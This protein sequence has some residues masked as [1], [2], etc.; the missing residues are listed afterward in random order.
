MYNLFFY[1]IGFKLSLCNYLSQDES[2]IEIATRQDSSAEARKLLGEAIK[3][4]KKLTVDE[5]KVKYVP[6]LLKDFQDE[7]DALTRR[8]RFAEKV[9]LQLVKDILEAP[10]P[11]PFLNQGMELGRQSGIYKDEV[12]RLKAELAE[13][14]A[15]AHGIGEDAKAELLRLQ[16]ENAALETELTKLSNQ[17]ITIRELETRIEEFEQT[18]ENQVT[19]RLLSR[20]SELRKI[21]DTELESVRE[22]ET[23]AEARVAALHSALLEAQQGRDEAQANLYN[24]RARFDDELATKQAETDNCIAETIRLRESL[25]TVTAALDDLRRQRDLL[26]TNGGNA[27]VDASSIG[28]T[29][30][31]PSDIYSSLRSQIEVQKSRAEAAEEEVSRLSTAINSTQEENRRWQ[32]VLESQRQVHE[33]TV[34]DMRNRLNL[35]DTDIF[36]LRKELQERPTVTEMNNLRHQLSVLQSMHFNTLDE[37]DNGDPEYSTLPSKSGDDLLSLSSNSNG[38]TNSSSGGTGEVMEVTTLMLKRI[39]QLETKLVRTENNYSETKEALTEMKQEYEKAQE[40]IEEQ[41]ETIAKLE[42]IIANHGGNPSR[43]P[44]SPTKEGSDN[45]TV[46][47]GTQNVL[48]AQS[49]LDAILSKSSVPFTNTYPSSSNDHPSS[50]L[51]ASSTFGSPRRDSIV[52]EMGTPQPSSSFLM[53]PSSVTENDTSIVTVLRT[54]RD[55]FR[56]RV[57]E[58]ESEVQARVHELAEAHNRITKLS[59][60]NVKMYEKIRFLQSFFI[61]EPSSASSSSSSINNNASTGNNTSITVNSG[62]MINRSEL[63]ARSVNA[64]YSITGE[65]D[66]EKDYRKAYQDSLDPF[67]AFNKAQ[68]AKTYNRLSS[69]D[70][71]TLRGGSLIAGN[72]IARNFFLIYALLLH[73]L[74]AITL[75]HFTQVSHKECIGGEDDHTPG[76][77]HLPPGLEIRK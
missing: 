72:K 60:D 51:S 29:F 16:R 70:K 8:S 69:A 48:T 34:N 31:Q 5:E 73:I 15:S 54:Q 65:D 37:D 56:I 59:G 55:R 50:A 77:N 75:W 6:T 63:R 62:V 39:R 41:R 30:S 76:A 19:E 46:G 14:K 49:Q 40:L 11:V 35:R 53:S 17:D 22:A 13:T 38:N 44:Y 43:G 26:T 18:I 9:F 1:L 64:P 24:I 58:L 7:V 74:I 2:S 47:N 42:D 10:D 20:E 66:I 4:Y 57:A 21:F 32:N 23:A 27:S 12:S 67:E 36:T 28:T 33:E 3:N 61:N 25:A 68:R 45:F 71:I 52:L